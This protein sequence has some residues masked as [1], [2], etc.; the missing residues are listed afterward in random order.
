[1]LNAPFLVT[2]R[3]SPFKSYLA[4]VPKNTTIYSVGTAVFIVNLQVKG[5]KQ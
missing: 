4:L 2:Q 1:M 3:A 5:S